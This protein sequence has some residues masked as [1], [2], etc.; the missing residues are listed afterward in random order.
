MCLGGGGK[1]SD[2]QLR[3]ASP[4]EASSA[5]MQTKEVSTIPDLREQHQGQRDRSARV[6]SRIRSGCSRTARAP[7]RQE[8]REQARRQ[9]QMSWKGQSWSAH[10]RQESATSALV[11]SCWP[12]S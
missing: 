2:R 8:Q 3:E 7:L 12:V 5:E 9:A 6:L 4:K 10:K 11:C 1:Y